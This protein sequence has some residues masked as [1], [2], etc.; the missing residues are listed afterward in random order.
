MRGFLRM[1]AG[2]LAGAALGLAGCQFVSTATD[3]RE[4][5]PPPP[6]Q[7][8]IIFV[9]GNGDTAAL[10]HTTIWRF[11]SNGYPPDRLQAVDFA[12]PQARNDDA[13]PMVGR[14][15]T[16]DQMRQL[17]AFVARVR[18]STGADKVALVANS[19]GANTVRNFIR[20]GG[21]A[22]VVSHAVLAG[23]VNHGVYISQTFN[24]GSEFNGAGPFMSALNAPYPD[25]G[26]V[27]P[28]VRW[29]TLRSDNFDKYAQP[30]GRFVG[31]PAMQTGITFDGPSLRGTDNVVL[32]GA[33][34]RETAFGPAAFARM[35][36]FITGTPAFRT[37][38]EP[39]DP[40]VLE[41]KVTGFL[42]GAPTN[43]PLVGAKVTVYRVAA[44]TG[45][46]MRVAPHQKTIGPDGLWGPLTVH[47]GAT[48]E[49]VIEADGY[50]VTHIYRSPFPRS[51]SVIHL[52][53]APPGSLT[54]D[55]TAAGSAVVITRPRGY[56]G[57]G[58]DTFLI[59][60]RVP[61]GVTDGVPGVSVARL[62]MPAAPLRSVATRFNDE[63]ITVMN[64]PASE[65]RIVYAEFHH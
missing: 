39:T 7:T 50:P 12:Y 42:N 35:Y 46:R 25:G 47:Q 63:R 45:A 22:A 13:T 37:S 11:E 49:F 62:R 51:S 34:H 58:R 30:D 19:R 27:T 20:N 23:G 60:G 40:V 10:W 18:Q 65:R 4:T 57:V 29:M 38:I 9:H 44:D 3:R 31:Q 59:D 15:D 6:M 1:I 41:G 26:E 5:V 48:L 8:P 16:G 14:S 17:A 2:L 61:P 36:Q 56:F 64:W 32:P 33:D 54:A 52:R 21:G 43:L 28:G 24:P 55:D 53:P